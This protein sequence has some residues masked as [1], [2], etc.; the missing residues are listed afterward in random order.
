MI[1]SDYRL[2]VFQLP[3]IVIE[4]LHAPDLVLSTAFVPLPRSR[5]EVP[6]ILIQS[7]DFGGFKVSWQGLGVYTQSFIL[8][9][10]P[11][12][13]I[14]DLLLAVGLYQDKLH[15]EIWVFNQGYWAKDPDMWRAIQSADWEDVILEEDFKEQ[16]KKD[17]YGFFESEKLYKNYGLP[18]K[19]GVILYGP[20]GNGKTISIKAVMKDCDALG[21]SPMYVKS[22]RSFMGDEYGMQLVFDKARQNAPCV[23]I[24]EDLDSLINDANR[25]FF[26]NQLDGLSSNDGLL[27]I[28]TTNHFDRLDPGLSTRPSR[29]DRKYLFDDPNRRGRRLYVQYW[30]GKLASSDDVDFPDS[31][32]E[33]ITDKTESFSFAYLKEV[34][35][36]NDYDASAGR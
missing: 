8:H 15:G 2:N 10:G 29:F 25:S 24:I 33:E 9:E 23:V 7:V 22:F 18:W 36:S 1:T 34:L 11:S 12:T 17:I 14:Q 4:P 16:I 35:P 3:G 26:L 32:A 13:P 30:Q 5:F 28:G 21:F 31:L 20:P 27:V 19:R 6:G